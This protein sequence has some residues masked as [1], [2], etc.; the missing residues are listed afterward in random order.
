M[1]DIELEIIDFGYDGEGVARSGGK[2]FFVP[3]TIVGEKVKAQI[4][5]ENAKFCHCKLIEV[6]HKAGERQDSPC[7]YFDK[8]GGCNFQHISYEKELE[9]KKSRLKK[10]FE[11]VGYFGEIPLV[12]SEEVYG[13]RN[14]IRFKVK[15][16]QTGFFE[17]KTN[18]FLSVKKC[19]LINDK[20]N[21]MVDKVNAFLKTNRAKVDEV[22][23]NLVNGKII[24]DFV[25]KEKLGKDFA[26][27]FDFVYLNHKGDTVSGE[28]QGIKYNFVG[29]MFRQVNESVAK[30]I[31][32]EVETKASGKVI[33]N[34]FSGAGVLSGILAKKASKVYGIELNKNAHES[35]EEMKKMNNI[36]SL[37]NICG[38]V[39]KEIDKIEE[40]IDCI[41]LDPPRAGCHR[42]VIDYILTKQIPS[43]IYV[44]CNP[45][46]LV[47]DLKL[48][49]EKFDIESVKGFDMFPRTANIETMVVLK[50][51]SLTK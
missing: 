17:E 5:K 39:E 44:S 38:Y 25:S 31:Y 15:N 13:Y 27:S 18:D 50:L 11:K 30:S 41:V 21:N 12:S 6:I 49:Q 22:V 29:D 48:L 19:L 47:R 16:G 32:G 10:E 4:V 9:I 34:A 14:K 37:E 51:K 45:A 40:Q 46:T 42:G 36:L 20:M 1:K 33:I 23:L 8:C 24:V 26:P 35:A 28:E 2:V 7:P 43:I 3:K